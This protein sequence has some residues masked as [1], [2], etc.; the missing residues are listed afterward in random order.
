MSSPDHTIPPGFERHFRQSPVTDPWEPLY[1]KRSGPD[2]ILALRID[3]QHCN[4]RGLLHGGVIS[5]LADN[6]MGLSCILQME[7]VS[8]LTVNL[9]VDFLHVGKIGHWLEVRARPDKLGRTLSFANAR[10]FA[11]DDLIA[12]ASATFR[13][14]ARVAE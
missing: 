14:I 2:F 3:R 7:N 11:D 1:I 13:I 10:I 12:R 6:A 5:A 8:A 9:A 4:A